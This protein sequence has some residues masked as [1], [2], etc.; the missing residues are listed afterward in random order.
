MNVQELKIHHFRNYPEASFSFEP[1][2]IHVF[3]GE[4][5]QG[6]TNILESIYYLS[7]LRSF[8]TS[9]T[10]AMIAHDQ[11]QARIESQIENKGRRETL[12]V[13]LGTSGKSQELFHSSVKASDFIGHCNAILFCPDDLSLF[14]ASPKNRRSFMD[15]E[16]VKLSRSYTTYLSRYQKLLKARNQ[17]LKSYPVDDNLIEVYTQQ[18]IEVQSILIHQR[19]E[20]I[21]KLE[22]LSQQALQTFS[23]TEKLQIRYKGPVSSEGD[24]SQK[25]QEAY[26]KSRSRDYQTKTT[27]VGIHKDDVEFIFNGHPLIQNASQ[28]Q[29]RTVLLAVKLGL[30]EMIREKS[31]QYP[32]LLLDD[33]FSELDPARKRKFIHLLPQGMQIF[34]TSAE[35]VSPSWFDRETR[36]YTVRHGEVKEGLNY[37]P[38]E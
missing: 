26:Q 23:D 19:S 1:G 38:D 2:A 29:K 35:A 32:I 36:F 11:K 27:T 18:M 33:V 5:A 9:K 14:S 7:H 21:K 28:G 31:G 4:N 8:R 24:I 10:T 3:Y 20:F 30:A 17:A 16:M 12:S 13:S 6:K 25:L 15:L 22:K 37:E 34:I